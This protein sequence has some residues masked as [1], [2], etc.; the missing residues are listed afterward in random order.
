MC[1][2]VLI[3]SEMFSM[4]GGPGEIRTKHHEE[5][6]LCWWCCAQLWAP[7]SLPMQTGWLPKQSTK[8]TLTSFAAEKQEFHNSSLH[9]SLCRKRENCLRVHESKISHTNTGHEIMHS[10]NSVRNQT[11]HSDD[12][13]ITQQYCIANML[14]DRIRHSNLTIKRAKCKN[15]QSQYLVWE[16]EK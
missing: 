13:G 12:T 5:V 8:A 15:S 10:S 3:V 16:F 9:K 2:V 14:P 11:W 1:F 7:T 6:N 4:T